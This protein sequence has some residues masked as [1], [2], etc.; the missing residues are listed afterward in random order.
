MRVTSTTGSPPESGGGTATW[1]HV[2]RR[3]LGPHEVLPRGASSCDGRIS[4]RHLGY[5]DLVTVEAGAQRMTRSSAHALAA[6][7]EFLA[8][9]LQDRGRA[10]SAQDGRTALVEPGELVVLTDARPYTLDQF[11]PFVMRVLRLPRETVAAEDR[12]LGAV[13]ATALRTDTGPAAA[14]VPLLT[15]LAEAAAPC[16]PH[17]GD[18]LA[19]AVADL[20]GTLIG[21][22]AGRTQDGGCGSRQAMVLRVR[23]HVNRHLASPGLTPVAIAAH[24]HVS[25]R[26]LHKTFEGE[27]TTLS[28]WIRQ[29]RLQESCR[30]LARQGPDALTVAEVARRWGFVSAAHFS[31]VFRAAYGVSPREW[32]KQAAHR[33]RRTPG[34]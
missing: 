24:L 12:A 1:N 21:D 4:T 16:P 19:G 11:D 30:Q 18:Q 20:V 28:R 27:G 2:V 32:R 15:A 34:V 9:C 31:R 10:A 29:R 6:G 8:V 7:R 33:Q 22:A 23:D 14:L 13:T 17:V 25:V 26:Y 5:A 3:S